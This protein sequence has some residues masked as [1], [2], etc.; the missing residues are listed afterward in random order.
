MENNI[1]SNVFHFFFDRSKKISTKIILA[2]FIISSLFFID[3]IFNLSY[4]K[5]ITDKIET[6]KRINSLLKE[7]ELLTINE[8][9]S[10][11]ELR[12]EI[13]NREYLF[14]KL[15]LLSFDVEKETKN[16]TKTEERELKESFW[17][18]TSSTYAFASLSLVTFLIILSVLIEPKVG[19][20]KKIKNFFYSSTVFLVLLLLTFAFYSIGDRMPIFWKNQLWINYTLNIIIQKVFIGII[21]IGIMK[22]NDIGIFNNIEHTDSE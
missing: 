6:A 21:G 18:I 1:F 15:K 20:R 2:V 4:N 10:L 19:N 14:D 3:Y 9:Q 12:T 16:I 11:I 22:L 17:Y 5:H 7:S 8:K 13:L